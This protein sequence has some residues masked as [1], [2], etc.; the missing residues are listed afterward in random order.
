MAKKVKVSLSDAEN[1][2]LYVGN[3][4]QTNY[5]S[6]KF[7]AV[8]INPNTGY[9]C[10]YDV[11]IGGKSFGFGDFG[12]IDFTTKYLSIPGHTA[13]DGMHD[14]NYFASNS[15]SSDAYCEVI[16]RNG[17]FGPE[18]SRER[19]SF[20][21][22]LHDNAKPTV[23]DVYLNAQNVKIGTNSYDNLL[24]S[25]YNRFGVYIGYSGQN[26]QG[27]A[28]EATPG[29][30]I[31]YYTISGSGV[32]TT[33]LSTSNGYVKHGFTSVN[34]DSYNESSS[35]TYVVTVV[36][37]RGRRNSKSI[38][39]SGSW[40]KYFH[41]LFHRSD[42][43]RSN[44]YGTRDENNG[45]YI[46]FKFTLQPARLNNLNYCDYYITKDGKHLDS[47]KLTLSSS[48]ALPY[49]ITCLKSL[50]DTKGHVIGVRL[51]DGIGTE[52]NH[53]FNLPGIERIINIKKNGLGIAFGKKAENDKEFTSD[54]KIV[55]NVEGSS[56]QRI[57]TNISSIDIDI[58]DTLK[59]VQYNFTH[60]TDEQTHYG[61]IAQ[62]VIK[63]LE[64]EGVEVEKIG[65]V[66]QTIRYG[67]Q[68][69]T[70]AYTEFI[71]LIVKKCQ[72][73]QKENNEMRAEIAEIK[74]LLLQA[75]SE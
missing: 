63:S 65:L 10:K 55:A 31:A 15:T 25:N 24:L 2:I 46:Y 20:T 59:P 40:Y 4:K 42:F 35:L 71:P 1:N 5:L 37:Q 28:W 52:I 22:K 67:E 23:G 74:Q 68:L 56:D 18:I 39:Y 14:G 7:E 41:P 8:D 29:S 66:G 45:Q 75:S 32:S 57:K 64:S 61:F 69:Y 44:Q 53:L 27:N 54:W 6:L 21:A 58:L 12:Q 26:T 34:L 50:D 19:V 73:L 9:Y 33:T 70:L 47:G 16:T 72:E 60:I 62:D 11:Y 36:D 30:S 43:Y 17:E 13:I 3:P 48:T 38:V 49:T 51:V